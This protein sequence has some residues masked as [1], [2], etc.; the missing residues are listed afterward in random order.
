M[1]K[2][3]L[4]LVKF[5]VSIKNALALLWK[6]KFTKVYAGIVGFLLLFSF[7]LFLISPDSAHFSGTK[8]LP[9]GNQ[10][11]GF[12]VKMLRM[13]ENKPQPVQDFYLGLIF[14]RPS[15]DIYIPFISSHYDG[16]DIVVKEFSASGDSSYESRFNIADVVYP[17]NQGKKI[18]ENSGA[19]SFEKND[20]TSAEE[21]IS[22]LQGIIDGQNIVIEKFVL[23]TDHM[24]RDVLSQI[25][26]ATRGTLWAAF[27]VTFISLVSGFI[28]GILA[29]L[30]KGKM[31]LLGLWLIR[32]LSSTPAMLLIIAVMFIIGNGFWHVCVVSGLILSFQIA[33]VIISGISLKREKKFMESASALGITRMQILKNYFLTDLFSPLFASVI[34]IFYAAIL[35]ESS[36]NFLGIGFRNNLPSWGGMIR[37]NYGYI[38]LPGSEYL[39]LLPGLAITI[40]SMLFFS[41]AKR[42]HVSLKQEFNWTLV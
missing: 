36:L 22:V 20:G 39:I 17:L 7:L 35:V 8:C 24:G 11:P 38:F 1:N 37:E 4:I 5:F 30:L 12:S 6:D 32:S 25:L 40:V 26:S 19:L 15:T 41:L 34:T 10:P 18:I 9:I 23:G 29:G 31:R 3:L 28:L 21:S 16:V 2:Y 14:G 13:A 42:S 27:I 33:Q